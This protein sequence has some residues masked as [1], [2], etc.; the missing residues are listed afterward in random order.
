MIAAWNFRREEDNF[1]SSSRDLHHEKKSDVSVAGGGTTEGCLTF[2]LCPSFFSSSDED[3]ARGI[4]VNPTTQTP[5]DAFLRSSSTDLTLWMR[6][7]SNSF[8]FFHYLILFVAFV[9]FESMYLTLQCVSQKKEAWVPTKRREETFLDCSCS[10]FLRY[11]LSG[12]DANCT[13]THVC[14]C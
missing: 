4:K 12:T 9:M 14:K 13:T 6:V 10:A 11:W 5:W 2:I 8:R 3:Y 1:S 7:S